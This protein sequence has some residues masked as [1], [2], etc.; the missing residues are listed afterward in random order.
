MQKCGCGLVMG[1]GA[2]VHLVL[3]DIVTGVEFL[4]H[5]VFTCSALGDI[6]SFLK[7]SLFICIP[8]SNV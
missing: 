3:L 4:E 8:T 6:A 5:N 1:L 2:L 7:W